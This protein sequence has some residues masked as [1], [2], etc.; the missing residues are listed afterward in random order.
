M[1]VWVDKGRH[2]NFNSFSLVKKQWKGSPR[3]TV[4][5]FAMSFQWT[6]RTVQCS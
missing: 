5:V 2:N 1:D 3:S 6:H 4:S